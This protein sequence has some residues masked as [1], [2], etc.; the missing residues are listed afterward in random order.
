MRV[1]SAVERAVRGALTA[2]LVLQAILFVVV[3][4][5]GSLGPVRIFMTPRS[6]KRDRAQ[7]RYAYLGAWLR[8]KAHT[9]AV[10]DEDMGQLA[11]YFRP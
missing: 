5:I 10:T 7:A 1:V 8:L 6:V 4:A 2:T 9:G 3:A 11:G